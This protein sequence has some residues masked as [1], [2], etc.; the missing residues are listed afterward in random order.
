MANGL[1]DGNGLSSE[2]FYIEIKEATNNDK[3]WDDSGSGSDKD[4]AFWKVT[5]S[6]GFFA[7]GHCV[8]DFHDIDP[9]KGRKAPVTITLKPKPGYEYLL[10]E[11]TGLDKMWDDG[12]SGADRDCNIWRLKCPDGYVAMG[13]VVTDNGNPDKSAF[14]CIKQTATNAKGETVALVS[15][16]TYMNFA[17]AGETALKSFWTDSGSGAD[18]NV[19]IWPMQANGRPSSRNQVYLVAGTFKAS[20]FYENFPDASSYALLLNF[21]E[22][23][24]MEKVDMANKK[25]K[26]TGAYLPTEAEM[27]VSEVTNEYFVPFFAVKDDDY[28]NQ[29]QQFR[30]SPTYKIRRVTRYVAIDSYAPINTE[31]KQFTVMTGKNEETN[32]NNEVGV[33]LGFSITRT[34]EAEGGAPGVGAAKTSLSMTASVE[35]SYS[36]SWGGST[37]Q[38]EE[39]SFMYPQTVTGGSFGALFQAKSKYT[40]YRAD[41]TPLS[42]P[43]EVNI[44]EFY[45]DEWPPKTIAP[46]TEPKVDAAKTTTPNTITFTIEAPPGKT[47]ILEGR[48]E[49]RDGQLVSTPAVISVSTVAAVPVGQTML[50]DSTTPAMIVNNKLSRSYTKEAWLKTS[51]NPNYQNII[52][53]GTNGQH[54]FFVVGG[55][56]GAGHNEKW[57]YV[58]CQE[59]IAAGWE[60]YALTYDA[61]KQE[62]KLYKNGKLV[63]SAQQ[64]PTYQGGNFVQVGRWDT[65]SNVFTGEMAEVRIWNNARTEEQIA[66][67]MNLFIPKATAGLI[68]KFPAS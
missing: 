26:L 42:A 64:V 5:P 24:I 38:Y 43:I 58:T 14:R 16:A 6:P 21:P 17:K 30:A 49:I 22:N 60:H 28:P 13:D 54:A 34:V 18:K 56:V 15:G 57:D 32:Y 4:V 39:R 19:A 53:G 12:G 46:A 68:A 8:T 47:I 3:I 51:I 50:F 55:K 41:G 2:F 33:T 59:P 63:S 1:F 20:R 67:N 44:N 66:S 31:T 36:H 25:F 37:S 61:D 7:L 11:P 48:L 45:T 23:D 27:Q 29:L 10:A 35:F 9:E 65:A 40:I 52:S 62:M